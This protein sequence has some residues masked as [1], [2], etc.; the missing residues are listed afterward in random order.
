M[1][2]KELDSKKIF[3]IVDLGGTIVDESNPEMGAVAEEI[4]MRYGLSAQQAAGL[5]SGIVMELMQENFKITEE[6]KCTTAI[7][8]ETLNKANSSLTVE[9]V[10]ELAFHMLGGE[11]CTYLRPLEGASILLEQ[12]QEAG[13]N[14]IA[15]SNTA[16][17]L[18]ILNRIFEVHK[19][20]D[21][22]DDIILS[23]ECGF[24]KPYAS[25]FDFLESK[26]D[27]KKEDFT[28]LLGN[29]LNADIVPAKQRGYKTV[30]LTEDI[31]ITENESMLIGDDLETCKN[32]ILEEISKWRENR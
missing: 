16:L 30:F 11:N 21:Y 9:Q 23:S 3:V 15:L 26:E 12:L 32:M 5:L 10:E 29:D 27:I 25:I 24:R 31:S 13:A 18:N 19:I 28:I 8:E 1:I 14:I 20:K 17:T 22:F 6:Q 4:T 2:K 7:I